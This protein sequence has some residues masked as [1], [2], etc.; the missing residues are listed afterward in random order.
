MSVTYHHYG[1]TILNV[2]IT[3]LRR[4][5]PAILNVPSD[6]ARTAE[7]TTAGTSAEQRQPCLQLAI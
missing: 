3:Q 1:A 6:L 7:R 2:P 5:M 4:D